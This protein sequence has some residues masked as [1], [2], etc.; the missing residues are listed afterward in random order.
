MQTKSYLIW[1]VL[2]GAL[3]GCRNDSVILN[4]HHTA[5]DICVS[6]ETVELPESTVQSERGASLLD[7]VAVIRQIEAPPLRFRT[8]TC[9]DPSRIGI[10]AE[11]D[12]G[13]MI[14]VSLGHIFSDHIENIVLPVELGAEVRIRLAVET[15][16]LGAKQIRIDQQGA[17]I[18]IGT[19]LVND[20]FPDQEASLGVSVKALPDDDAPRQ[21]GQCGKMQDRRLEVLCQGQR[22]ILAVGESA[23]ICDLL[24]QNLS[25]WQA[26]SW[27][28][29]DLVEP[30]IWYASAP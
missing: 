6:F 17:P 28:C 25:T 8:G 7:T 24:F 4:E 5:L 19:D 29:S 11:L 20:L 12:S 10:L 15:L 9:S 3:S 30:I 21:E 27:V 22:L 23:E 26:T 13:E 16:R 1:P 2:L 14:H 18:F